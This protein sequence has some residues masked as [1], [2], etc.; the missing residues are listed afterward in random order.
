MAEINQPPT[1]PTMAQPAAQGAIKPHRGGVVLT[2]GIVGVAC[3]LVCG[4]IAWVMGKNDLREMDAGAMD[5]AGRGMTQ[6]GKICGIIGVILQC[7][8]LAFLILSTLVFFTSSQ[9]SMQMPTTDVIER[10]M[11]M[12]PSGY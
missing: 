10:E 5:P 3:C 12:P 11:P 1:G 6:A 2:L 9:R 4:I 8:V 7:I